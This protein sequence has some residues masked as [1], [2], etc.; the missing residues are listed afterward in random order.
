MKRISLIILISV[1][2]VTSLCA[3]DLFSGLHDVSYRPVSMRYEAMGG[4]GIA[5][6]K[7]DDAFFTNAGAVTD[8]G[9]TLVL[10]SIRADLLNVGHLKDI[11]LEKITHGDMAAVSDA[12][13]F[14]SG[15]A[16]I[17][18]LSLGSG[19]RIRGFSLGLDAT[20]GL[21]S[22]GESVAAEFTGYVDSAVSA[23]YSHRF[24]LSDEYALTVGGMGHLNL[25]FSTTAVDVNTFVDYATKRSTKLIGGI[26]KGYGVSLDL[27]A[28]L[29]M[30]YG[31]SAAITMNDI[32]IPYKYSGGTTLSVPCNLTLGTGWR[33]RLL[34]FL[35]LQAA[36]D[37]TDI[38]GLCMNFSGSQIL[39]HTNMGAG[40]GLWDV[41]SLYGGL[42]GGY[43]SFGARLKLFFA[44]LSASYTI[45]EYSAYMGYNPKDMLS[46][47]LR[48]VF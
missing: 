27:G 43:P 13:S 12:V 19:M 1:F 46:I 25:R 17:V 37:L 21:F 23:G 39:Y 5:L 40:I 6:A 10:P 7:N 42:K 33:M 36:V 24:T 11:D 9:F 45:S 48:L 22:K 3:S 34:G 4:S 18:R 14:L 2:T 20:A 35:D 8:K 28:T 31:F 47:S 32:S 16:P 29:E 26:V 30:P 15:S 38:I 41:L 44:E